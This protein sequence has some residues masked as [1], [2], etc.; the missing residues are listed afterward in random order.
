MRRLERDSVVSQAADV[1]TTLERLQQIGIRESNVE[2][3]G[4]TRNEVA[5]VKPMVQPVNHRCRLYRIQSKGLPQ[6][7]FIY[8]MVRD[9]LE[10]PVE[11]SNLPNG[12]LVFN[13]SDLSFETVQ[14]KTNSF[15]ATLGQ[16]RIADWRNFG[17]L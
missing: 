2:T 6:G 5:G 11:G 12:D 7:K 14:S 10:N 16:V 4:A 1:S 8:A 9:T 17:S 3:I 15:R 13:E